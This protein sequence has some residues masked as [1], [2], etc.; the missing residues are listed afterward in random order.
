MCLIC[1]EFDKR[2]MTIKEAR[3][4]LGEMR[5]GLDAAHLKEVERKLDDAETAPAPRASSPK[6]SKKP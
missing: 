4:A 3:R 5:V 1:I 2:N 6:P